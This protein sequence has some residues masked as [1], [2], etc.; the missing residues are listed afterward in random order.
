M[1]GHLHY[2]GAQQSDLIF[3]AHQQNGG[4]ILTLFKSS[5]SR[6]YTTILAVNHEAQLSFFHIEQ[7]SDCAA[8]SYCFV[9]ILFS[10]AKSIYVTV[11]AIQLEAIS[12]AKAILF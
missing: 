1:L 3:C 6:C 8:V 10:L 4:I 9:G 12:E 7:Y 5:I 11:S 2:P